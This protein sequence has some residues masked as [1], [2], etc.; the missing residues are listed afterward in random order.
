MMLWYQQ[1][2]PDISGIA[3]ATMGQMLASL[4][5]MVCGRGGHV[6]VVAM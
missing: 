6:Y 1:L 3:G 5:L 4:G 2:Q